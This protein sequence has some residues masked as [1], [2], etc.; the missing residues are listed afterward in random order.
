M[1][2][3][4]RVVRSMEIEF[5]TKL[6][7]IEL[8]LLREHYKIPYQFPGSGTGNGQPVTGKLILHYDCMLYNSF[9]IHIFAL[10][11]IFLVTIEGVC[12]HIP[13]LT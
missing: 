13:Q 3:L 8:I 5:V 4:F 6:T 11:L 7:L 12:R 9:T 1:L 2:L 10:P